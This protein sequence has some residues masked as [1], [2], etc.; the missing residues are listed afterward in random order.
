MDTCSLKKGFV[1]GQI[2]DYYRNPPKHTLAISSSCK[3]CKFAK[4]EIKEIMSGQ[5][6]YA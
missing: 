4:E 5:E 1:C 2:Q 3:G 6:A